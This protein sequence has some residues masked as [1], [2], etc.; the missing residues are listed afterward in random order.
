MICFELPSISKKQLI[1]SLGV[2]L[3]RSQLCLVR[4]LSFIK[5]LTRVL[6]KT[7]TLVWLLRGL[8]TGAGNK[9]SRA[10]R[11]RCVSGALGF[12]IRW[13]QFRTGFHGLIH[14]PRFPTTHNHNHRH[15]PSTSSHLLPMYYVFD[16][17]LDTYVMCIR[18]A[19]VVPGFR[20]ALLPLSSVRIREGEW[21]EFR[22]LREET[23][24]FCD[25]H[26]H[27]YHHILIQCWFWNRTN[28][29]ESGVLCLCEFS[30]WSVVRGILGA[31]LGL[32]G[33]REP[34]E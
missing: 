6:K 23:C 5:R 29:C 14:R 31:I 3:W 33:A 32:N 25:H 26:H 22:W 24:R 13:I 16:Y 20:L 1:H 7:L 10:L 4:A 9:H 27:H 12:I 28:H 15:R 21:W 18:G 30:E 17:Y 11:L 34:N 2:N 19:W 8:R